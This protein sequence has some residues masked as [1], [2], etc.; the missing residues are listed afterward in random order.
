MFRQTIF[1]LKELHAQTAQYS[2]LMQSDT[3]AQLSG[4]SFFNS[5]TER[6]QKLYA[7]SAMKCTIQVM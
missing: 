2:F 4:F 3:Q 5:T 6:V 7:P 1:R